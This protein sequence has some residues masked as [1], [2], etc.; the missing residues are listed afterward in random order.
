MHSIAIIF[1]PLGVSRD[2]IALAARQHAKAIEFIEVPSAETRESHP[3]AEEMPLWR[4][5][6]NEP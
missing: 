2:E 1:V 3:S 4:W 5:F 6:T